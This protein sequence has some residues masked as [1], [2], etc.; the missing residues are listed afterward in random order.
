MKETQVVADY[1]D[2]PVLSAVPQEDF[3]Y[4]S[5]LYENLKE[6]SSLEYGKILGNSRIEILTPDNHQAENNGQDLSNEG[7]EFLNSKS[8]DY[9]D[10]KQNQDKMEIDSTESPQAKGEIRKSQCY[11][12]PSEPQNERIESNREERN[13]A[14]DE[15]EKFAYAILAE[16]VWAKE[17]IEK[18]QDLEWF[19]SSNTKKYYVMHGGSLLETFI[20]KFKLVKKMGYGEDRTKIEVE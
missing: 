1:E 15:K 4:T 20:N 14:W 16:K 5:D 9:D 3:V 11:D 17:Q 19:E 8:K 12:E 18:H 7:I 6:D 13:D 10:L 2:D